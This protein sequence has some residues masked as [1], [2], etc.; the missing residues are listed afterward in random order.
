MEGVGNPCWW[1]ITHREEEPELSDD[2]LSDAAYRAS[3]IL[4]IG[5][6]AFIGSLPRGWS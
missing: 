4:T 5:L 3:K 2:L 6:K 1:L